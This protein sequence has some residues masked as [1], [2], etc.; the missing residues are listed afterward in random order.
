MPQPQPA[1]QFK[2]QRV[3]N[4][5][6]VSLGFAKRVALEESRR[7][8]QCSDATCLPGCPLEIDI[9]GF[10]RLLREGDINAALNKI[11]EQNPFPSICGRLC[12]APCETS[13]VFEPENAPIGIRALERYAADH[14]K[15][16][17]LKGKTK[18][19]S[20]V[21]KVGIIGSGPAGLTAAYEL[22]ARGYRV[23]IFESM[24]LAGGI[25]RYGIPEFRLPA[26]VLQAE[27]KEL[28]ALG[29]E[30]ETNC[31]L[32]QTLLVDHLFAQ[33]FLAVLLA[34]GA[35]KPKF[36]DIP[37]SNLGGVFY[38]EEI[39][40]YNN[41]LKFG[42]FSKPFLPANFG[43]RV[44]VIG[45][46][47]AALDCA[48]ACSRWGKDVTLVFE[49]TEEEMAVYGRERELGKEER[50]RLQGL[51]RVVEIIPDDERSPRFVR[52]IQCGHMDFADPDSSGKWQL[53]EAPDSE[54]V[55]E[56]D[57]V[58]LALGKTPSSVVNRMVA[59]LKLNPNGTIWVNPEN[60]L[61]SRPKIFAAGDVVTC[62]GSMVQAMASGKKAARHIDKF[63]KE[64]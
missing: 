19:S 10:I 50:V 23:K 49:N 47:H 20:T 36:C 44:V 2:D 34:F 5:Q 55:R 13:C 57:T 41:L 54:F 7:C 46:G 8:P 1:T 58:V 32:G 51:T 27:I 61:T 15:V 12:S 22:A 6:E 26:K 33:G 53:M 40:M 29:V 39:L 60:G 59:D 30:I 24:P 48:R 56:A 18:L 42:L 11:K 64:R 45:N 31:R 35:A 16:K 21:K 28:G 4:F 62:A 3:K 25:L 17:S 14:G 63:L 38:A 9:P 37:G 43:S 52:G